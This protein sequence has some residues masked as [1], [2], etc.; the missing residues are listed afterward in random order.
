MSAYQL[1]RELVSV[2]QKLNPM[3]LNQGTS[4]NLS[5]RSGERF[6]IT[7]TGVPYD[8]MGPDDV[9]EMR[10]DGS[11]SLHQLAPSS[12]WR[13]HRDLY[14]A[15]SDV[16]AVLHVHSMF[17]TTLSCLRKDLPAVHYMIALAGGS[18]VRCARYATFGT[19]ALSRNALEALTSRKAC[20]LANHGLVTLGKN[21]AEALKVAVEIETICAQYLRALQVGEPYILDEVEMARVL[22]RFATYGQKAKRP[23]ER[24]QT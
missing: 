13:I 6:L 18:D 3:G 10:M 20:L 19:E 21:L 5:A 12:E 16:D 4:G 22:E 17:A 1:R 11:S 15:R 8:T 7:P 24:Q 23:R 2:A 14:L 9:V